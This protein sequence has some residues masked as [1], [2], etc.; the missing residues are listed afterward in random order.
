VTATTIALTVVF[1]WFAAVAVI[2]ALCASRRLAD[3]EAEAKQAM[4]ERD[5]ARRELHATCF[6]AD[7]VIETAG[8]IIYNETQ[9]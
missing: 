1:G 3:A 4:R 8:Q 7:A 2:V 9:P 6:F 5:A